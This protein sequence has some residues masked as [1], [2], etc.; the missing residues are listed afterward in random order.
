MDVVV[1]HVV[2][3]YGYC[4]SAEC[5]LIMWSVMCKLLAKM[6][7]EMYSRSSTI[8]HFLSL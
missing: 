5:K 3:N 2:V 4:Q 8:N 7:D 6:F 1:V